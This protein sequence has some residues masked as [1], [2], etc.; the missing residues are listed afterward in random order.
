MPKTRNE[1]KEK[2]DSHFYVRRK[3]KSFSSLSIH[4]AHRAAIRPK[5]YAM[6]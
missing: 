5:N 2:I 3:K 6:L 1:K 4:V